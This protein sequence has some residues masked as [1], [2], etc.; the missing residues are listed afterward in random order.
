MSVVKRDIGL[1]LRLTGTFAQLAQKALHFRLPVLQCFFLQQQL[2]RFVRPSIDEIQAF[3]ALRDR[4]AT[5]FVHAAYWTN[6]AS[7]NEISLHMFKREL[8]LAKK[9]GFNRIIIHPGCAKG[10]HDKQ[11][12]VDSLVRRLNKLLKTEHEIGIVLENTAHGNLS[13]GGDFNDFRLIL[14]KCEYPDKLSFCI[15]TAH[16][17]AFGYALSTPEDQQQFFALLDN[18]IGSDRIALIHLNNSDQ[19]LGSC[20][21]KHVL[22]DQGALSVDALKQFVLHEKLAHVPIIMEL[23]IVDESIEKRM[24]ELVYSW[25]H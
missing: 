9:L 6:F 16:A 11:Q 20:I 22:L 13:L 21:D 17:H 12:G 23:P 10:A 1:H 25:H 24:L 3:R 19:V 4:F 2:N 15:D 18:T 8:T 5:L 14:E 7:V